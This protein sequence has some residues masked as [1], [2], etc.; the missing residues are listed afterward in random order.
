M[1][2][3]M[4]RTAASEA[5]GDGESWR[6][7]WK[8]LGE[9]TYKTREKPQERSQEKPLEKSGKTMAGRAGADFGSLHCPHKEKTGC[10][11]PEEE[12]VP[13]ATV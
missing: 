9:N 13:E 3:D 6:S 1:P 8:R 7:R 5:Y 10:R 4:I 11:R 12:G 2:E